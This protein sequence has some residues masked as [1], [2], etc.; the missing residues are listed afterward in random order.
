MFFRRGLNARGNGGG[1][2]RG[3]NSWNN[4][5]YCDGTRRRFRWFNCLFDV[6]MNLYRGYGR[7]R[8]YNDDVRIEP[9]NDKAE[10]QRQA[11]MLKIQLDN[12]EKRLNEK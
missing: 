9:I 10:L 8:Y 5:P 7:N 1:M 6:G 3:Y 11:E 4:S 12:I 2:G